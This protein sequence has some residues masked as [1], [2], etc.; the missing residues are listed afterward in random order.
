MTKN[1]KYNF[2]KIN[3]KG[4]KQIAD[5]RWERE[6]GGFI[7]TRV[8]VRREGILCTFCMKN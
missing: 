1:T 7:E 8:V 4:G 5:C 2:N 6:V 3:A